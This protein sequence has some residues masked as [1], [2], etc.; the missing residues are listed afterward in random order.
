MQSTYASQAMQTVWETPQMTSQWRHLNKLFLVIAVNY[1][2]INLLAL[3]MNSCLYFE[4]YDSMRFVV[5]GP[6]SRPSIHQQQV[7]L[8]QS[9]TLDDLL[10]GSPSLRCTLL[11]CCSIFFVLNNDW[12]YEGRASYELLELETHQAMR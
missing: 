6:V 9:V 3:S 5:E 7:L 11:L 4:T 8:P 12:I 10:T 2:V 1:S